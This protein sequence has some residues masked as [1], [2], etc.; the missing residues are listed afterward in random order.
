M[1][2]LDEIRAEIT[3]VE[4]ESEGLLTGLL[5]RE[6]MPAYG[7]LRVYADTSV[8][9]GCQDDEFR[10]P[11]RRLMEQCARGEVTLVVS[12]A[13]LRELERAPQAVRDVLGA[14]G[15]L[16]EV[17]EATTD[18]IRSLAD[19]YIESGALSEKMRSDAEHIAAATVAGVDVLASWNFRHMVNLRRIRQYNEVNRQMGYPPMDIRSPKE[20]EN[21]D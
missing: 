6:P 17:V 14:L 16:P 10:E 21:E 18:E 4:R 15:D 7:K 19:R 12:A 20:L 3:A 8:I 1:R 9:G 2:T 11:S 13:T 5:V